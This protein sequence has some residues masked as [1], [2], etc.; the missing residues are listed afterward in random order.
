MHL[1]SMGQAIACPIDKTLRSLPQPSDH[2]PVVVKLAIQ[3]NGV[4]H[5][6]TESACP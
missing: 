4:T 2:T 6:R 1:M 3:S 5:Y